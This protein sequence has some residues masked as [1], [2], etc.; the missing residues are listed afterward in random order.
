LLKRLLISSAISAGWIEMKFVYA[1]REKACISPAGNSVSHLANKRP[2]LIARKMHVGGSVSEVLFGLPIGF[3]L[4]SLLEIEQV[5][6]S[7]MLD[8]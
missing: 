6:V 4:A 2:S 1:F 5:G 8:G 7:L 3:P